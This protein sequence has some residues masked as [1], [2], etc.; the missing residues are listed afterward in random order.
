[1]SGKIE[2]SD[3]DGENRIIVLKNK[4]TRYIALTFCSKW[5]KLFWINFQTSE[6]NSMR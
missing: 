4:N 1:M 6:V 2:R 3:L 5:R